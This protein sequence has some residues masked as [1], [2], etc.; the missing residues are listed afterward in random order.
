MHKENEKN[1][2]LEGE[3]EGEIYE[4]HR[5]ILFKFNAWERSAKYSLLAR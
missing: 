3:Q 1:A 5:S 2:L 4:T